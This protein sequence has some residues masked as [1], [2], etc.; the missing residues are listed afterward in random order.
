MSA[1]VSSITQPILLPVPPVVLPE[2]PVILSVLAV[3]PVQIH[4]QI[5]QPSIRE[6]F[7]TGPL[8]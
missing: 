5:V 4:S 6:R 3:A 1:F 2:P 7:I 8:S